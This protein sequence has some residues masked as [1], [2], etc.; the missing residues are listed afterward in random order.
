MVVDIVA[1][2]LRDMARKGY[3]ARWKPNVFLSFVGAAVQV[4]NRE[5]A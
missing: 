3:Q 5:V 2:A 1:D 4:K